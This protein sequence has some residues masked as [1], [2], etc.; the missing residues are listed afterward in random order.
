MGI[1]G[2]RTILEMLTTELTIAAMKSQMMQ[3]Y[4]KWMG[5]GGGQ[6]VTVLAFYSDDLSSNPTDDLSFFL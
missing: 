5:R 1:H 4:H 3:T 6:V 2:W